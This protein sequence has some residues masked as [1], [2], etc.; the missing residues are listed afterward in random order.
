M[1]TLT[2]PFQPIASSHRRGR[3]RRAVALAVACA[4]SISL[5]ALVAHALLA[6][7]ASPPDFTVQDLDDKSMKLSAYR[8][9]PTV[10]FLEDK[11]A[12]DQNAAFK[13]RLAAALKAPSLAKKVFVFPIADVSSWNFWPAKGFVRDALRDAQ[14]SSGTILYADWDGGARSSLSATASQSNV[15]VLD[16]KGK[17][18]WASAGRLDEKQQGAVISILAGAVPP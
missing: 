15:V 3:H 18:L 5:V 7:G 12:K 2:T 10:V 14:K 17:V 6:L 8:G 16:A 11:D 9:L 1:P 4:L 13:T